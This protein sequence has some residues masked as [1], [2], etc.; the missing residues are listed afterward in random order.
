MSQED[1]RKIVVALKEETISEGEDII[2]QGDVADKFYIIKKGKAAVILNGE[3]VNELAEGE[4]FG[5]QGFV[6][7]NVSKRKASIRAIGG[8]VVLFALSRDE[9]YKIFD[10][11]QMRRLFPKRQA[12]SGASSNMMKKQVTISKPSNAVTT[13]TMDDKK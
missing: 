4:F 3:K 11:K 13:K 12:I 7:K 10:E 1:R 6:N 5:E 8:S 9:F 2:R